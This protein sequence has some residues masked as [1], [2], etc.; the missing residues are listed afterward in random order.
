M[1]RYRAPRG[2][3][4]LLPDQA[5]AWRFVEESF[6]Q[7]CEL[8]GFAEIRT[9][10]FESA[11]LFIRAV[12]EHTDI[13]SKE[14][15][16]V[17]PLSGTREADSERLALRPEG[18]APALRAYLEHSLG[19][20][21]PLT[22]LYY[23]G[24]IF[25]H[26]RPQAGRLRQHHQ[27]GVEALGSEDPGLD[28]EIIQMG[29]RFLRG[30]GVT[31]EEVQVNSVG[32][33]ECR[34]SYREALR[35]ALVDLLPGMCEDC[36]RR[37]ETN[38][39][40][41][42]DCKVEEW[43]RL[44]PR[45]PDILDHLCDACAAHHSGLSKALELLG[46]EFVRS[47]RLVRGFDYYVRTAFEITHSGLGAQSTVIG[48]GRYDGLVEELGGPPTPGIGFGCGIERVLMICES[49]RAELPSPSGMEAY[50]VALAPE[51]REPALRL[52]SDLRAA[53]VR[54]DR[55]AQAR[56]VKAQ[57]RSANRSGASVVLLIGEDELSRGDVTLKEMA[58]GE[59]QSVP[60][61]GIVAAVA[62]RLASA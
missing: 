39:M 6:R 18:T 4:D 24:P 23:I 59:Q 53:G 36:N 62:R 31:G 15:Y 54:A 38:P 16:G 28:A 42:L 27:V 43:G 55:D 37:Y 51:A 44:L 58:T 25:R 21:S 3:H 60:A 32:C 52:V 22:R 47:P 17:A 2:L 12:G 5:P 9:P 50:V 35:G 10:A 34:P 14:M 57:M 13:I 40:R 61:A 48:G 41:I 56:S 45:I 30:L 26:E 1:P 46:V 8:Y 11:D 29:V 49:I 33:G 19:A 7:V 20:A